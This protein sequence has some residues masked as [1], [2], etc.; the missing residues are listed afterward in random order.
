MLLQ[1]Y[2]YQRMGYRD[3]DDFWR[4]GEFEDFGFEPVRAIF[5]ELERR[6]GELNDA[7]CVSV[8]RLATAD[9][10]VED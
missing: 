9:S 3:L 1:A 8:G 4:G 7:R 6:R 2:E 10:D 5:A